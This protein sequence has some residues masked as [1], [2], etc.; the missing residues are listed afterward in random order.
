MKSTRLLHHFVLYLFYLDEDH[1]AT[2]P[3]CFIFVLLSWRPRGH[4]TILFDTYSTLMKTMRLLHHFVLYLFYLD[5]DHEATPSLCF[6]FVLLSSTRPLNHYVWYLFYLFEDHEAT[7]PFCLYLFY[8]DED[9]KATPPFCFIFLL[10]WWSPLGYSTILFYICSTLMKTTRP[11]HHFVL[12]L[13]YFHEDHEAT[14]PFCLILI[15]PWWRPWGYS[16]ILFYICSTLMR[17]TRL[18]HH[19]VLDLFYF[20][21]DHEATPLFCVIFV[22]PW[23]RPWD[24]SN[25]MFYICSSLM[26]T[27]RPH[28][29]IMFNIYSTLMKTMRLL[30]RSSPLKELTL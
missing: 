6:I 26:K 9:H 15:L 10:P 21:E 30:H 19:F 18:L 20:D 24:H 25:I 23:W 29:S 17:T 4:S 11:L 1:K 2:P 3:F 13:F 16:T 28:S 12:Y 7:Q 14:P 27:M 5:E 22:L 8:L